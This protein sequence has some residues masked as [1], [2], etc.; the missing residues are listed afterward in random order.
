MEN[1]NIVQLFIT[2]DDIL[3]IAKNLLTENWIKQ[4][5]LLFIKERRNYTIKLSYKSL[6]LVEVEAVPKNNSFDANDWKFRK[7][8]K[9]IKNLGNN[10]N[11]KVYFNEENSNE[12]KF[13]L[14]TLFDQNYNVVYSKNFIIVRTDKDKVNVFKVSAQTDLKIKQDGWYKGNKKIF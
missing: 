10:K 11:Y 8:L 13:L 2:R 14:Y 3:T 1:K 5:D 6:P 9:E 7:D 4:N 12:V